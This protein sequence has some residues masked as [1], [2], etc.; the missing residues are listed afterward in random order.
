MDTG[1]KEHIV[2]VEDDMSLAQWIS[3]YLN[4]NGYRTSMVMRGDEAVSIIKR[5]SPSLV[6]LDI[7]LPGLDGF[8]VCKSIRSTYKNPVL[9]LTACTEET[10]EVLSLELGADDYLP[11]PVKPRV[12]LAR[13]KALLRRQ[14]DENTKK[15]CRFG[16]L[17]ID[18]VARSVTLNGTVVSLSTNEFDMLWILASNAG[19]VVTRDQLIN[20]LRGIE[21]DGLDR[22]VDI[23]VSRLRKKLP[24]K[25]VEHG[26]KTVWGKGYLFVGDAW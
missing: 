25:Y 23:R 6:I 12:L 13:V 16:E 11:K 3:D 1:V 21:Y 2:I 9:M 24:S 8:D 17:N 18:A 10:D 14:G 26:I 5:E 7:M 4:D 19:E 15:T 20:T 22:S